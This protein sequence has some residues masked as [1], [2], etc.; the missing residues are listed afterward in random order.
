M[1]KLCKLKLDHHKH[2]HFYYSSVLTLD[3]SYIVGLRPTLRDEG[4]R[5]KAKKYEGWDILVLK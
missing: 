2:H 5:D 3:Y 4:E 1:F